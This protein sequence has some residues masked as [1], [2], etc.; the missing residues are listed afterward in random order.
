[1]EERRLPVANLRGRGKRFGSATCRMGH[2]FL[3]TSW[4]LVELAAL[5][6]VLSTT[7]L[8]CMYVEDVKAFARHDSGGFATKDFSDVPSCVEGRLLLAERIETSDQIIYKTDSGPM[9]T[10]SELEEEEKVKE[11]RAWQMLD[12]I[13]IYP[14]QPVKP[15]RNHERDSRQ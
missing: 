9:R 14:I 13:E 12:R 8:N 4:R 3:S 1:M 5:V 11:D 15:R 2:D 10:F 7:A 6:F